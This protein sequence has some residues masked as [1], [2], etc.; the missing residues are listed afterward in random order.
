MLTWAFGAQAQPMRICLTFLGGFAD[1][2]AI[3]GSYDWNPDL[4]RNPGEHG[5]YILEKEYPA[6]SDPYPMFTCIENANWN[7]RG[8]YTS[9]P[10][11]PMPADV[12]NRQSEQVSDGPIHK[13][14]SC[15]W[16]TD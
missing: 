13:S 3:A 16:V 1:T 2:N 15:L 14:L 12:Y 9:P 5:I 10:T 7:Y 6:R 4:P 8:H 11:A